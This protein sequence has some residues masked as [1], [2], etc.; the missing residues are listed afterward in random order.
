MSWGKTMGFN[1]P[2][3]TINRDDL[4]EWSNFSQGTAW[5]CVKLWRFVVP[6]T[7]GNGP[8]VLWKI[9]G[10]PWNTGCLTYTQHWVRHNGEEMRSASIAWML[11]S[12]PFIAFS[13]PVLSMHWFRG[14]ST[15]NHGFFPLKTGMGKMN[16]WSHRSK[17]M[18]KFTAGRR[19]QASVQRH[20]QCWTMLD[21]AQ[22]QTTHNITISNNDPFLDHPC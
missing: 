14:K 8:P 16:R 1:Q 11:S 3:P 19:K 6:E 17:D 21:P 7:W 18:S 4:H 20:L 22:L 5:N 13:D 12:F 9:W 2:I 10:I 15:G